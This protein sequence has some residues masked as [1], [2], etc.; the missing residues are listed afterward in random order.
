MTTLSFFS[1][2]IVKYI[3]RALLEKR[4]LYFGMANLDFKF[5]DPVYTV[6]EFFFVFDLSPFV[7]LSE[8]SQKRSHSLSPSG[9]VDSRGR[10]A[11]IPARNLEVRLENRK[12]RMVERV[13]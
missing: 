7:P 4:L 11:R 6:L 10:R 1:K 9:S 2:E 12:K 8:T 3:S 5:S 13:W